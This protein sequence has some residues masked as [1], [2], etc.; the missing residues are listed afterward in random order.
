[1]N[2]AYRYR[3]FGFDLSAPFEIETLRPVARDSAAPPDVEIRLERLAPPPAPMEYLG[4]LVQAMDD[5]LHIHVPG[6]ADFR[7]CGGRTIIASPQPGEPPE[8]TLDFLLGT[9]MGALLHQRGLLPLHANVI[10]CNGL[11][12]AFAGASG[13]G[14]S[15]LAARLHQKGYHLLSD[16]LCAVSWSEGGPRVFPGIPRVKLWSDALEELGIPRQ[17]TRPLTWTTEKFEAPI[18]S[19]F[20]KRALPLAAICDLRTEQDAEPRGAYVLHGLDAANSIIAHTYRRRLADLQGAGGDCLQRALT[21]ANTV[22]VLQLRRRWG[23]ESFDE[24]VGAAERIIR[25]YAHLSVNA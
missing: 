6:I 23:F 22:P 2:P 20:G 19:A 8:T 13:V 9:A 7:V 10:E 4:L 25:S 5:G 15:T 11:A 18:R 14:K 3:V 17:G 1:M 12:F 21:L 24:E 16:D